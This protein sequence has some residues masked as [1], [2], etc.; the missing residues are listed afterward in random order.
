MKKN[1]IFPVMLVCLLALGFLFAGCGDDDEGNGTF[2]LTNIPSEYEGKYVSLRAANN[3]VFLMGASSFNMSVMTATFPP[4]SNRSVTV[5]MWL[6]NSQT[7][8]KRYS[9]SHT[10]MVTLAFL[11]DPVNDMDSSGYPVLDENEIV[12]WVDFETVSFS[13]GSASRS[14]ANADYVGVTGGD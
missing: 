11:K 13:N 6:F 9:G 2:T 1:F 10:V 5:P 14:F 3:H 4:I 12:T 8:Y 7:D